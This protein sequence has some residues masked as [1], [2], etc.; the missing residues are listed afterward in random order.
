MDSFEFNKIAGTVLFTGLCLVGLNIV[1]EG[2]FAQER[3]EKP[4]FEI[5]IKK[6]SAAAPAEK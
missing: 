5:D 1:A 4:G 6:A 3:P 2:M